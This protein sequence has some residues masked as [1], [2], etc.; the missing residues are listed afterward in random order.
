MAE[1]DVVKP[2]KD[3]DRVVVSTKV[4]ARIEKQIEANLVIP[5]PVNVPLTEE[6]A[7]AA[8]DW[9]KTAKAFDREMTKWFKELRDPIN[10]A[11]DSVRVKEKELLNPL[12]TALAK[13]GALID[14]F[15]REQK[16]LADERARKQREEDEA[17]ALADR[18]RQ[19]EALKTAAENAPTE[20]AKAALTETVQQVQQAPLPV[21]YAPTPMQAPTKL[22]PDRESYVCEVYDFKRLVLA[23][24]IPLMQQRLREMVGILPAGSLDT[25]QAFIDSMADTWGTANL[26]CL[27]PNDVQLNEI[28][29][30]TKDEMPIPGC[31]GVRRSSLTSGA[32][33][34]SAVVRANPVADGA[35]MEF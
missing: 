21:R 24:S 34:A 27:L 13:V 15:Q 31:R 9:W 3:P 30:V 6:T 7:Q 8:A 4:P 2:T 22:V 33:K 14:A 10:A 12:R 29:R 25:V 18:Q 28:A 23:V 20:T 1:S 11:A 16:R 32:P 35:E 17:K 19:I 5:V 26:E